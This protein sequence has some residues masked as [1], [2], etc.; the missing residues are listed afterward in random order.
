MKI[1]K[2]TTEYMTAEQLQIQELESKIKELHRLIASDSV[3]TLLR[4]GA[5]NPSYS[6]VDDCEGERYYYDL[7]NISCD[8]RK[9]KNQTP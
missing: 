9:A 6:G 7:Y 4:F 2:T 1:Q 3:Y 5:K 8:L